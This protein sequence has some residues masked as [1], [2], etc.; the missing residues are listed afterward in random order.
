MRFC[1]FAAARFPHLR[2]ALHLLVPEPL[3][4]LLSQLPLLLLPPPLPPPL[5]LLLLLL[6]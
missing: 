5:L 4:L 2:P 1:F 3:S 6:L